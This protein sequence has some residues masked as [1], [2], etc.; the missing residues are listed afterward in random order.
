MW[1]ANLTVDAL[2]LICTWLYLMGLKT[3]QNKT[4]QNNSMLQLSIVAEFEVLF[5]FSIYP[6]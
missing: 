6:F 5:C 3:K 2:L 1:I 4:Q